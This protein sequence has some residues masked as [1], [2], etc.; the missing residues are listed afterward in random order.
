MKEAQIYPEEIEALRG[1]DVASVSVSDYHV[2]ALTYRG[3]IYHWGACFPHVK[4][5]PRRL[6][7]RP[8]RIEALVGVRVR[9]VAS[10]GGR[11]HMCAVTEAGEVFTWGDG[12]YGRLGHGGFEDE[13]LPRRV[14]Q[15]W[16]DGVI[17]V[18]VSAGK[19]HTLVAGNDGRVYGAGMLYANGA[20]VSE[21]PD[22]ADSYTSESG[23]QYVPRWDPFGRS[24]FRVW[25]PH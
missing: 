2:L 8:T 11:C 1:V 25:V 3:E 14:E 12:E 22:D 4:R 15:L 6:Q 17:V 20:A 24:D 19:T 9:A 16:E 5:Q 23:P 10:G 21:D 18:G 7:P 13:P